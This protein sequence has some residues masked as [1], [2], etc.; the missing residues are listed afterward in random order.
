MCAVN[1]KSF[2]YIKNVKIMNLWHYFVTIF[3][4]LN[5]GIVVGKIAEK[6]WDKEISF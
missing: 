3:K 4:S 2:I 6:H 1:Q 5:W